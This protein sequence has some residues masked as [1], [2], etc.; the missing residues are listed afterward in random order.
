ML[1][2]MDDQTKTPIEQAIE[3][4]GS[5]AKLGEG[6]G[7]SQVAI[8]KAKRRGSVTAEMALKIH[9]FTDGRVSASALRPDL[10]QH[11]EDV[12]MVRIEPERAAS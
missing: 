7:C 4:A 9:R 6:I 5:E 12:P 10:W 8:N 2:V 11:P 1:R 3:I